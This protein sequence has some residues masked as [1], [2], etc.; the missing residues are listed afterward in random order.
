MKWFKKLKLFQ[1]FAAIFLV[2]MIIFLVVGHLQRDQSNVA[3]IF[4]KTSLLGQIRN[5]L[6]IRPD[7]FIRDY[8]TPNLQEYKIID[9]K[10]LK[11]RRAQPRLRIS[12]QAPR[13]YRIIFGAFDFEDGSFWGALLFNPDGKLIHQWHLTTEGLPQNSEPPFR[14]NM[15]GFD[16]LNDGSII[17]LMQEQGG[18]IVKV[19]YCSDRQWSLDGSFHH[20]ISLL[21]NND[22]FWTLA[23]SQH[24]FDPVITQVNTKDGRII[25]AIDM[26]DVRERNQYPHIFD[27]GTGENVETVRT[28]PN[29]VNPL[30]KSL[31]KDFPQ[32]EEGDLL[33]SYH[34]TNLIF[35]LDP[36]TLKIKWW[37]VGAW[38]SQHDPDWNKGGFIS[39]FNNNQRGV[40]NNSSIVAIDPSTFAHKTLIDGSKYNFYSEFN[41]NHQITEEGSI[42]ISS[43]TQGRIFEVATNGDVVFDF[44]NVYDTASNKTLHISGAFFLPTDFWEL[45]KT[46]NCREY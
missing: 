12:D 18:G 9:L 22:S 24:D 43:S 29:A 25:K 32:F 31:V 39:V 27:V 45:D 36:D 7:R 21:E 10:G 8:P 6:N 41:G 1:K 37:R 14:K 46:W 16:L 4:D 40:G 20:A 13:G 15:Y 2:L 33:I 17:F 11:E 28:H 30:P 5:D 38:D 26:K 3:N 35:I 19:D 23:G 34:E 44:V 42:L